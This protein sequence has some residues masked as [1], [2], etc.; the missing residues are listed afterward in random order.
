MLKGVKPHGASDTGASPFKTP[1]K[2]NITK[3]NYIKL[4]SI[5]ILYVV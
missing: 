2:F 5:L 4:Y 3:K 1:I